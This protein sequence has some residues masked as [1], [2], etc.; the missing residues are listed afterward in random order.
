MY[1]LYLV[2]IV[3]DKPEKDLYFGTDSTRSARMLLRSCPPDP[4]GHSNH[5]AAAATG[6]PPL[7]TATNHRL[8]NQVS[9][10]SAAAAIGGLSVPSS[11]SVALLPLRTPPPYTEAS[12][13]SRANSSSGHLFQPIIAAA[14]PAV[15]AP[16]VS[17]TQ[18]LSW[19]LPSPVQTVVI[20]AA[21]EPTTVRTFYK[22]TPVWKE[23]K[24]GSDWQ[25][26]LW[27]VLGTTS[28]DKCPPPPRWLCRFDKKRRR[29]KPE[30]HKKVTEPLSLTARSALHT[31]NLNMV[32]VMGF[33]GYFSC[34]LYVYTH[35]QWLYTHTV[36]YHTARHT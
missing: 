8:A 33:S 32:F 19:N 20:Q 13:G 1:L 5:S 21:T 25:S 28:K 9:L 10:D 7:A 36:H 31:Q 24:L 4:W 27:S 15:S 6:R 11:A 3:W 17:Q 34:C 18:S 30:A 16:P 2:L 29:K 12:P 26:H 22:S 23:R 35:K 14:V